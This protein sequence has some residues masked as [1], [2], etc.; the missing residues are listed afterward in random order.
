MRCFLWDNVH[1]VVSKP[2]QNIL[3]REKEE[4]GDVKKKIENDYLVSRN[5]LEDDFPYNT[6]ELLCCDACSLWIS[7]F[8]LG[9]A[10]YMNSTKQPTASNEANTFFFC[11]CSLTEYTPNY[12][13][14]AVFVILGISQRFV[15][16]TMVLVLLLLSMLLSTLFVALIIWFERESEHKM[17]EFYMHDTILISKLDTQRA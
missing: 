17:V 3:Q 14:D 6:F 13:M 15:S 12:V 5:L 7:I 16:L 1:I 4:E 10:S 8:C 11:C 9:I 2:V